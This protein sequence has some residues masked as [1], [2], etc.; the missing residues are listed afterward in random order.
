[1]RNLSIVLV[2]VSCILMAQTDDGWKAS[3]LQPGD[4]LSIN[5]FRVNEFSKV[6]RIEEDGTF[7]YPTCG[8][9]R[10]SGLTA[11]EIGDELEKRLASQLT[12][13][14]V[15]VFVQSWGPRRIYIL[16][17]VKNSM[18]MDLPTYGRMTALQALSAAGGFTES[19]DLNN[20]AVLRRTKDD[21]GKIVRHKI[22]VSALVSRQ[23]GG[24]DFKLIPEDTLVVPKAPPVFIAGEVNNPTTLYIDTQRPP[25]L[26]ELIIRA[27]NMKIG[28]DPS[29][30]CIIRTDNRGERKPIP[31]SLKTAGF[32]AYANDQR[33]EPG[34]Y[35]LVGAAAQIYV[36]GEVK[37]PGPLTLQPNQTVTA[38]Q[39]I[40]LAGNFTAV[41]KQNDIIYISGEKHKRINLKN[42]YTL[43]SKEKENRDPQLQ[44]GDIIF[45]QESIW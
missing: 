21:S 44:N 11:R 6:V 24:D 26:S 35:V 15:D 43:D 19:A 40:A 18:S 23:S 32:G 2:L 12:A 42:L 9:I 45:V 17:E 25:L 7:N 33:I 37:K 8:T 16:G 10:A 38:S 14:H 22:D 39:A 20:V 29:N 3:S 13:P 30:I 28:A 1:M 27:G 4:V 36:L 31:A 41:A 5:V 34:D